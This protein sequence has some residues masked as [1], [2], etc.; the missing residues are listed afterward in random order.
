VQ[1]LQ[2]QVERD[3]DALRSILAHYH[4]NEVAADANYKGR[5][6]ELRGR[7]GDIKKEILGRPYVTLGTGADFEIPM[8]QC[9]FNVGKGEDTAPIQ[10]GQ[11]AT[12]RGKVD[13]L[14]M[15]VLLSDCEL[16]AR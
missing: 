13:G 8:V 5:V 6:V 2:A 3:R 12:V 15:N 10:P 16:V 4:D 1:Q 7:V 11:E 14:M 9:V